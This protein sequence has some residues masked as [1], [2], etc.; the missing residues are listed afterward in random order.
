MSRQA[1]ISALQLFML[2]FYCE[3]VTGVSGSWGGIVPNM[4]PD[5]VQ[6]IRIH[7]NGEGAVVHTYTDIDGVWA[8]TDTR[9]PSGGIDSVLFLDLRNISVSYV[10]TDL[11][12]IW[13]RGNEIVIEPKTNATYQFIIFNING[14]QVASYSLNGNQEIGI[15]LPAGVYI[16]R[17][18]ND[19]GVYSVKLFI[20]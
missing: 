19:K 3:S 10:Q 8:T 5:G 2:S 14:K 12:R 11:A 4:N 15:N 6:M 16:G 18:Q 9:N 1:L 7:D 20:K 17:L 13:S